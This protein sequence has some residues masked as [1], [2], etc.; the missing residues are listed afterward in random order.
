MFNRDPL[1]TV[2]RVSV[3]GSE[4]AETMSLLR[5]WLDSQNIQPTGFLAAADPTPS[6]YTFNIGFRSPEDADRFRAEFGGDVSRPS[7]AA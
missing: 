3:Q 5:T 6:G 7:L 2:V 4:I 1:S